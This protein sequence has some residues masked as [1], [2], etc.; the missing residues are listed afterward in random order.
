MRIR[1]VS[2]VAIALAAAFLVVAN[3]SFAASAIT[4][5]AFGITIGTLVVSMDVARRYHD[6][7]PTLVIAVLTAAVSAWTIVASLVFAD[8]TVQAL[9]LASSLAIGGLA[10]VGLTAHELSNERD[11]HSSQARAGGRESKLS[12]AA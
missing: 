5:L 9:T 11:L 8:A 6:H 1:F 4:E 2:W 10:I 3:S 12:A 7:I